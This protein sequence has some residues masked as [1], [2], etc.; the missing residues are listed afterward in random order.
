MTWDDGRTVRREGLT[1]DC[2]L[3]ALAKDLSFLIFLDRIF[4]GTGAI[5]PGLPTPLTRPVRSI[6]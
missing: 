6:I 5:P 2:P 3:S 1:R 4:I